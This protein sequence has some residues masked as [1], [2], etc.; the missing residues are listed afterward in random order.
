MGG[1][2]FHG[3]LSRTAEGENKML[4]FSKQN[5]MRFFPPSLMP[6]RNFLIW[7]N[8]PH[9]ATLE[10]KYPGNQFQIGE[11]VC[12]AVM[13]MIIVLLLELCHALT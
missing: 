2:V 8:H 9:P 7:G 4:T 11:R 12:S 10:V 13:P 5:K 6:C 3:K 1:L